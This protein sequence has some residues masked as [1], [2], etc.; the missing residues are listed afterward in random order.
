MFPQADQIQAKREFTY[1]LLVE[2]DGQPVTNLENYLGA[3]G[4][5]VIIRKKTLDYIH[6]YAL[7]ED[8]GL[9]QAV[10][11]GEHAAKQKEAFTQGNQIDFSITFPESGIYNIFTQFQ[12]QGKIVTTDYVVNVN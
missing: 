6:T 12:H 9:E 10:H 11:G 7:N 4:H 8:K 3:K 2:K 5:S 1:S